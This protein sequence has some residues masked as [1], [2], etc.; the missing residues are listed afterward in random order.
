[1]VFG[2]A[3]DT[4]TL[5][6][7]APGGESPKVDGHQHEPQ[8]GLSQLTPEQQT[9]VDA[10]LTKLAK[11][12]NLEF[13]SNKRLLEI[14]AEEA[15]ANEQTK[16]PLQRHQ[17]NIWGTPGE[18]KKPAEEKHARHES[19]GEDH[20]NPNALQATST[21]AQQTKELEGRIATLQTSMKVDPMHEDISLRVASVARG[22]TV[23]DMA[24]VLAVMQAYQHMPGFIGGQDVNPEKLG[25]MS[26]PTIHGPAAEHIAQHREAKA[27]QQA[28]QLSAH[29]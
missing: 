14:A 19:A 13:V 2:Q 29:A 6:S 10:T 3:L 5:M 20:N 17:E 9:L 8:I 16:D 4:G 1:M 11:S 23:Q 21:L 24:S 7:G 12:G 27:E 18:E 15:R 25:H 26:P 28:L 22:G